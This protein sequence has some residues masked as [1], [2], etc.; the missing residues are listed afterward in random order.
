M[1]NLS[2]LS[3][4]F[5]LVLFG[6]GCGTDETPLAPTVDVEVNLKGTFGDEL[7][8]MRKDYNYDENTLIR[9]TRVSFYVSDI[10]LLKDVEGGGDEETGL[11]D[12]ELFDYTDFTELNPGT[13]DEGISYI[14]TNIPVDNYKGIK[15]GLGVPADLN[16]LSPDDQSFGEGHPLTSSLHYWQGWQ[17]YMFAMIEG[18]IDLDGNG[19]FETEES[20]KYHLGT[21]GAYQNAFI[22]KEINLEEGTNPT[23]EIEFDLKKVFLNED[24][25][26]VFEPEEKLNTH[27]PDDFD[28]IQEFMLYFSRIFSI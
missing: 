24:G 17:S 14:G 6:S 1:K 12:L 7:L 8:L 3:L 21:D 5:L 20:F 23:I 26:Q 13:A 16:R 11:F 18:T 4:L 10:V 19:T 22:L 27:N 9:F 15:L 2:V 28:F 25:S